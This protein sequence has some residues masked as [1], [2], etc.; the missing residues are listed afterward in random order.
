MKLSSLNNGSG[1]ISCIDNFSHN[2]NVIVLSNM[3]IGDRCNNGNFTLGFKMSWFDDFSVRGLEKHMMFKKN[4][5][6]F[7]YFE[8][9][10]LSSLDTTDGLYIIT[11]SP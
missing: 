10:V 9:C 7:I 11:T 3:N 6:D 1:K 8:E 2:C 5:Y 4:I